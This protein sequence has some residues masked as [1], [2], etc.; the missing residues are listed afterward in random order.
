[1]KLGYINVMANLFSRF[2][3]P[4]SLVLQPSNPNATVHTSSMQPQ[5]P[6]PM[7]PGKENMQPDAFNRMSM[8]FG[9]FPPQ[10]FHDHSYNPLFYQNHGLAFM[11]NEPFSFENNNK[12]AQSTFQGDFKPIPMPHLDRGLSGLENAAENFNDEDEMTFGI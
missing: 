7:H 3:F 1:M 10:Y 8:P 11:Y 12:L 2:D 9:G 4:H 5:K 6:I